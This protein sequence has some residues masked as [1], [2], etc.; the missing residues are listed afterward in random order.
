[1]RG[2][3]RNEHP[4][5]MKDNKLRQEDS[6]TFS[7][8]MSTPARHLNGNRDFVAP[9]RKVEHPVMNDCVESL[10]QLI[11]LQKKN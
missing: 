1:M 7:S 4:Q 5:F 11:R 3:I 10:R 2:L 6:I 9:P 8:E